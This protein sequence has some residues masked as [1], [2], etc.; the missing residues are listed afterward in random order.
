MS[1]KFKVGE[2]VM[3]RGTKKVLRVSK[4]WEG[5]SWNDTYYYYDLISIEQGNM[6]ATG[7]CE[8]LILPAPSSWDQEEI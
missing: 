4:S 6:A 2:K 3:I 8:M 5:R 7:V 1:P